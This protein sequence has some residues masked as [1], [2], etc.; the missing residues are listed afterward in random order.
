MIKVSDYIANF[1][2]QNGLTQVFMVVGGGA[3]HLD[4]SL[5]HHPSL[6]CLY[7]HHEQASAMAAEAYSRISPTPGVVC[8]TSGPGAINAMNGVAGAFQDSIPMLVLSGQVKSSLMVRSSGLRLRT[9][10]G[11]EFDI[12]PAVGGMTKYAV[13]VMEAASIRYEM[14]KALHLACSGRPGPCWIDVPVDIQGQRIDPEQLTGF[15]PEKEGL[16]TPKQDADWA[17]ILE[18]LSKATRP[19]LYA[20]NSIRTSGGYDTFRKLVDQLQIPVVTGWNS[21]D[22]LPSQHPCY[23]GRGGTMGDRAGNFA[24]QNSDLILSL[25]SRLSIYQVGYNVKTWAREACVIAVDIDPEELKKPTIRV[26]LPVCMDVAAFMTTLR[27]KS[28][29][30]SFGREAWNEQ[31]R[32][33]KASYPVVEAKHWAQQGLCNVYAFMDELGKQTPEGMDVVVAN[34]SASVV[35]SQTFA[36]KE[37]QRFIMNCAI[38]SMGY[39][40]PAAIG[41]CVADGRAPIVCVAGDGSIQMNIQELQTI[42]TNRLPIKIFVI[43]NEGY[44]QIRLTQRNLFKD[45]KSIGLGPESGDLGFPSMEKLAG[46]YGYEYFKC[47]TNA[48]LNGFVKQAM[49]C[50][51]PLIAEVFV[52]TDQVYEPKSATRRLADGTLISPPLEDLAPF[53][54]RE[55]L[56][57]NMLIPTIDGDDK[58]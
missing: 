32:Q 46:A 47:K 30:M 21:I 25:G 14:E 16:A 12:I 54:P 4:D 37:N 42:L 7:N 26:N 17:S 44:H 31:C 38:S 8:V 22:L 15:D 3:M 35:G 2:A 23:V 52:D 24:V 11:Q 57:R 20:G 40:L 27:Q 56:K 34:G 9:L 6:H 1:L 43:N 28:A 49:E 10:G 39:D 29:G 58:R 13:T 33:W 50:A 53:L 36:I 19:V 51:Q 18:A 48:N 55:E 45:H 5:G 41:V